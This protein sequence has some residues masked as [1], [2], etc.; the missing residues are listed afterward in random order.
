MRL[1]ELFQSKP[2]VFS[3]EV[4]PPRKNGAKPE[5]L[6]PVLEQMAQLRPDYMSVTYGAG[7]GPAGMSTV[8]IAAHLKRMGIEPLAHLTCVNSCREQVD[9]VAACLQEKGVENVLALRGDI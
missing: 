3:I 1:S 2:C 7:G 9:Q 6:Y 4:F 8:Q 5:D